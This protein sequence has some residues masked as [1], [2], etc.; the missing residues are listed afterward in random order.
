[1]IKTRKH[2]AFSLIEISVVI[3][4]IGILIA[5]ISSGIELYDDYKLKVAQNL[6]KN[7][8]VSRI[9]NLEL[10]L[11]TTME[12]RFSQGT[13]SFVDKL[14]PNNNTQIGRWNDANP[15]VLP[16]VEN[17]PVQTTYSLQPKYISKGIKGLPALFFDGYD[18]F[19]SYN[20]NF[21]INS[22]YTIF[23]VDK[24][25][26][27]NKFNNFFIASVGPGTT[28]NTRPQFGY[29]KFID[30]GDLIKQGHYGNDLDKNIPNYNSMAP[31]INTFV[32]SKVNGK[33]IYTNGGTKTVNKQQILPI[34]SYKWATIGKSGNNGSIFYEGYIGEMIFYSR[35]LTD[36]ERKDVETYLSNKWGI[37]LEQ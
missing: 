34:V 15:N 32:F 5:G 18:N 20:G 26:V 30:G 14:I 33:A 1:M 28:A 21:L 27:V 7:S 10:W 8:R 9:N 4:V 11:E 3:I 16:T 37:K 29:S 31:L 6:T 35:D 2:K 36:L 12:N 19:L 23:V 13:T 25:N 22:N 17:S 24:R